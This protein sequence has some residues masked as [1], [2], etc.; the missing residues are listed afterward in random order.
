MVGLLFGGWWYFEFDAFRRNVFSSGATAN[1]EQHIGFFGVEGKLLM[2][3]NL[4][5]MA[6]FVIQ[7]SWLIR[8]C[9]IINLMSPGL[10]N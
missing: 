1:G 3:V 8:V 5:I 9:S 7:L 2:K 10:M 4:N 6:I